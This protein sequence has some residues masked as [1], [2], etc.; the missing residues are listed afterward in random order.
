[1]N[2]L[3]EVRGIADLDRYLGLAPKAAVESARIALNQTASR[4]GLVTLREAMEEQVN[5]PNGYLTD[6]KRFGVSKRATNADLEARIRAR[7]RPTSL[8]RFATGGSIIG[9]RTAGSTVSVRVNP[10]R[11]KRLQGAFLIRLRAGQGPVTD[12]AFNLGL[13]VRLKKGETIHNKTRMVPFGGGLYL[14]YGPSVDQVFQTVAGEKSVEILDL[15][16]EE[17]LRQ[18]ELR[19]RGV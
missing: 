19:T 8:A 11:N 3:I 18:F 5:F 14:L 12:E 16:T 10:G 17:F 7:A 9:A 13:A 1:M 2:P 15:I 6:P 4:K